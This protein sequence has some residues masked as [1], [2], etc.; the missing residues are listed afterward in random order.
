MTTQKYT[1]EY[2]TEVAFLESSAIS[3]ATWSEFSSHLY[4]EFTASGDTY[5]Y[6]NVPESLFNQLKEAVSAGALFNSAI[7]NQFESRL[8]C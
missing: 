7:R 8:Y 4:L 2:R 3:M 6:R 5:E 1:T